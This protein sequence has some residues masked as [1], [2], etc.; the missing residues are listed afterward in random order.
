MTKLDDKYDIVDKYSNIYHRTIKVKPI[1]DGLYIKADDFG[2]LKS[3]HLTEVSVL[4]NFFVF[5]LVMIGDKCG[6]FKNTF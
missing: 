4:F 1:D 2:K 6:S 3:V 5:G